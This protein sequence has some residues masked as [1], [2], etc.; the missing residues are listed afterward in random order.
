MKQ[1]TSF[2]KWVKA[3]LSMQVLL[4]V[5]TACITLFFSC[6]K[7]ILL[8]TQLSKTSETRETRTPN[9]TIDEA[10]TWFGTQQTTHSSASN[11]D[12]STLFLPVANPNWQQA[13]TDF[14][15]SGL[16]YVIAPVS[17]TLDNN[18]GD[19]KL[20]IFRD[21]ANQLKG[22]YMLYLPD[23]AYRIQT[24]G[25]YT[26]ATFTGIVVYTD[27]S[28]HAFLSFRIENGHIEKQYNA[29]V[30]GVGASLNGNSSNPGCLTLSACGFVA[31]PS[32]FCSFRFCDCNGN[33]ST[34]GGGGGSGGVGPWG[35]YP[36]VPGYNFISPTWEHVNT[37]GSGSGSSGGGSGW[38]GNQANNLFN[39][40]AQLIGTVSTSAWTIL[41]DNQQAKTTSKRFLNKRGRD[42]VA[43]ID[44]SYSFADSDPDVYNQ[45]LGLLTDDDA[46][47]N[48]NKNAGFP[49]LGTDAWV[50][51][52]WTLGPGWG[53]LNA[54]EKSLARNH[55]IEFHHYAENSKLTIREAQNFAIRR[56]GAAGAANR[57]QTKGNDRDKF[58]A[59]QHSYWNGLLSSALGTARAKVWTD[60][61][62]SGLPNTPDMN[63]A[64]QMDFF[65]NQIGRDSW[66]IWNTSDL[67]FQMN[68]S[69]SKLI[70]DRLDIGQMIYICFDS[71]DPSKNEGYQFVN[72]RQKF[73]NQSCP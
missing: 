66:D 45:Y 61:H 7:D 43:A 51:A 47:F 22:L 11:P 44:N 5:F 12:G 20:M 53:S 30:S 50:D 52:V 10:K 40:D 15:Q 38:G 58:N 65:N 16:A 8:P 39:T 70:E 13:M 23:E 41:K 28:G 68:N 54:Q 48:A 31:A 27:F 46:F 17:N 72:Q 6:R 55:P 33:C 18:R 49:T 57:N 62:E 1:T 42:N 36:P 37:S 3:P 19:A 4:V 32:P 9:I 56:L 67:D 71:F 35:S 29:T 60:A 14:S 25:V 69:L 59:F 73:T 64:T 2:S 63:F 21:S 34:G 24:L 26:P